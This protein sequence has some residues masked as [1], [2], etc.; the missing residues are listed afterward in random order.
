MNQTLLLMRLG[1]LGAS[2]NEK[3]IQV[4]AER[5][6]L[7]A[8]EIHREIVKK[9]E[10]ISYQA[11]HK[12]L[13]ALIDSHVVSRQGN[14][15]QLNRDWISGI[16]KYFAELEEKYY[17]T[18]GKYEFDE[19]KVETIWKFT[20]YSTMSLTLAKLL[21]SKK[22]VGKASS[23]GIGLLRHGVF[24][25]DF[26][27][28]DFDLLLKMVGYSKGGYGLIESDTPLD[29]WVAGQYLKAGMTGV[30]Y[31]V[32][33]L[34]LKKDFI[35][36]GEHYVEITYSK[37]TIEFLDKFFSETKG[38]EGLYQNFMKKKTSNKLDITVRIVKNPEMAQFIKQQMIQ[39]YFPEPKK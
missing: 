26:S 2:T 15:F 8:K 24:P 37:D 3:I 7:S 17:G 9:G 4:L 16:K 34:N 30:K 23:V 1:S 10:E 14:A 31:G 32:K 6:P 13:L 20:D 39:K 19:R 27:F 36:H 18:S 21:M 11:I 12:T 35:V 25:L 5:W 22:L 33:D 29:R 28:Y 38:I